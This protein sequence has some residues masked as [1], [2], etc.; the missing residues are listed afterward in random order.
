VSA[1]LPV[2]ALVGAKNASFDFAPWPGYTER[3]GELSAKEESE[4]AQQDLTVRA[5]GQGDI[6]AVVEIDGMAG[7]RPRADYIRGRAQQT[8]GSEHCL[9]I[10]LVAD[11]GGKV[12]GFLMGRVYAGEF[13]IPETVATVD[14]VGIHP[15]QQ[16]QGVA[17]KLMEEFVT[18][19][20]KDGVEWLRTMV[21]WRQWDLIRFFRAEGFAPGTAIVLERS[22]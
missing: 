13:G 5:M 17:H 15:E 2:G 6:A 18:L 16:R 14:T 11:Q 22:I 21:D 20:R 12:V 3:H 19:A 7:G 1:G 9:A 4:M 10:S 8:L